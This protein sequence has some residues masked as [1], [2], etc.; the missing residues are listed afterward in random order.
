M[1]LHFET[2]GKEDETI[3]NSDLQIANPVGS[4]V[5]PKF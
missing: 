2:A 1:T 4:L 3:C 5:W